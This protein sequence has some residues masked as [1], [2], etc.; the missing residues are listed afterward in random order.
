[1]ITAINGQQIASEDD[2]RQA[3]QGLRLGKSRFQIRRGNQTL[4]LEIEC[5]TCNER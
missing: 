4:T 5:P 3:F 2:L 1:V